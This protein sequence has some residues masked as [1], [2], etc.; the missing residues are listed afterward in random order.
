MNTPIKPSLV[1]PSSH[2]TMYLS[3][4]VRRQRSSLLSCGHTFQTCLY[5][6]GYSYLFAV[7]SLFQN[8]FWLLFFFPSCASTHVWPLIYPSVY[9]FSCFFPTTTYLI[10]HPQ[11]QSSLF[12]MC[13]LPI[14]IL[15]L[16]LSIFCIPLIHRSVMHPT[17][18][19]HISSHI[20]LRFCA[21]RWPP[22]SPITFL[23]VPIYSSGIS[24][25]YTSTNKSC[26][27]VSFVV[28][29]KILHYSI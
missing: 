14:F 7:L 8:H 21:L 4:R 9:R 25:S 18:D 15:K 16:N 2:P 5:G 29:C 28:D 17:S 26:C 12:C 6:H 10:F 27:C 3:R 23:V 11:H 24:T 20:N 22:H 19:H 1:S 13:K